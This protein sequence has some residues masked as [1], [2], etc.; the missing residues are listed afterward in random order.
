MGTVISRNASASITQP[1]MMYIMSIAHN[2]IQEGTGRPATH[3]AATKGRRVTA[4][5]RP[6][7]IAPATSINIMQDIRN[8]SITEPKNPFHVS[9]LR[10]RLIS[11]ATTEPAAPASD[12]V[13]SPA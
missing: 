12:G 3:S 4:R 13:N 11:I 10:A 9:F 6:K 2:I 5:K 7:M 8:V 1:P